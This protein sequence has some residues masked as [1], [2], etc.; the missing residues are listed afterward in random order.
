MASSPN[1]AYGGDIGCREGEGGGKASPLEE[2]LATAEL[3][4]NPE[5]WCIYVRDREKSL[6]VG[7][8]PSGI[9]KSGNYSSSFT[10]QHYQFDNL[11][12]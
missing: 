2:W 11:R 6:I 8:L 4:A 5:W 3:L 7:T 1:T 12:C 9:S 10:K